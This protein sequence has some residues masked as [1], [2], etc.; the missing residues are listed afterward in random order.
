MKH[1]FLLICVV[2]LLTTAGCIFPGH[3]GGGYYDEYHGHG[4]YQEHSEYQ[5]YPEREMN[6]RMHAD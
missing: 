3:R 1:L 6:G 2:T 5:S 4:E